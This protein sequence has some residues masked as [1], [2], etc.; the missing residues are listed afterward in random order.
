M[1]LRQPLRSLGIQGGVPVTLLALLAGACQRE[2]PPRDVAPAEE[3]SES[4][5]A[6][7]EEEAIEAITGQ[8]SRAYGLGEAPHDRLGVLDNGTRRESFADISAYALALPP[9]LPLGSGEGPSVLRI[10]I[11][12]NR[13]NFSPGVLDGRW[14]RNTE[15]AVRWFQHRHDLEPTG[16]VDS[17]TYARLVDL[18]GGFTPA[19]VYVVTHSDVEGPFEPLP[20]D[21]YEREHQ[22]CL[23]YESVGEYLAE[24]FHTTA[25][26][27]EHM[28]PGL[29][30]GRL[31]PATMLWVPNV[32]WIFP[33]R[34]ES[35][36]R[37]VARIVVSRDDFYTH[38]LDDDGNILLHFPSTLGAE[39]DPS[40]EGELR[41][42][43]TTFE[44]WF[45][46][47]PER[48]W[49]A[50]D[51][52]EEAKLPPGPN[53]PV[54]LVWMALS[55]PHYGIHGTNA[56]ETIGYASSA[57][58]VRLTNWDAIRLA[59]HTAPGTPVVFR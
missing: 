43:K 49:Y 48:L 9:V 7:A 14:G 3:V 53:S 22:D 38:A 31:E 20:E 51:D 42:V 46:Y 45:H 35:L 27:L 17:A 58:C 32:P 18:A 24:R 30:L 10:Q 8:E 21:V 57:G 1:K 50:D 12:L 15:L 37:P 6:E 39:Y 16:E 55:K 52:A 54:G 4:S 34:S 13:V 47:Q 2:T 56:P 33:D 40:P 59:N 25:Q 11:M 26:I 23:C 41:V 36:P 19:T 44:P 28:N 29:D 5:P